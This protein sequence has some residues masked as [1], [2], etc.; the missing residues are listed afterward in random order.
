MRSC[1]PGAHFNF[2]ALVTGQSVALSSAIQHAMRRELDGN[3]ETKVSE[4]ETEC[5]NTKIPRF[6]LPTRLCVGYSVKLKNIKIIH[7]SFYDCCKWFK[8]FFFGF[9]TYFVAARLNKYVLKYLKPY[10]LIFTWLIIQVY[11]YN[12]LYT[13]FQNGIPLLIQ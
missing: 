5:R 2:F 4:W 10:F 13:F 7:D 1:G 8:L 12:I 11:I 6:P 3:S 9:I